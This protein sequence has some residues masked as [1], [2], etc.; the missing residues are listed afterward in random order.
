L[1]DELPTEVFRI[2]VRERKS[3]TFRPDPE[4]ADPE[5]EEGELLAQPGD[6]GEDGS[7]GRMART[8]IRRLCTTGPINFQPRMLTFGKG[9]HHQ[10]RGQRCQKRQVASSMDR[11][12]ASTKRC[13][14]ETKPGG[15]AGRIRPSVAASAMSSSGHTREA[16]RTRRRTS[17]TA[18]AAPAVL[19]ERR[20]VTPVKLT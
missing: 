4:D 1:V 16:R 11:S 2:L 12:S 6:K 8:S 19:W 5:A 10:H 14:Y 9:K 3:M 13:T 17:S 15:G 7:Y 18:R 20:G